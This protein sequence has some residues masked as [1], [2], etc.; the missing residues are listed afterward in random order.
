MRAAGELTL[1]KVLQ[2]VEQDIDVKDILPDMQ[3]MVLYAEH[4]EM[5]LGSG[6]GAID[7][8]YLLKKL[9]EKLALD[10]KAAVNK[11]KALSK[12]KVRT[13]MVQVR[14]L[15]RPFHATTFLTLQ[16]RFNEIFMPLP[17]T[18]CMTPACVECYSVPVQAAP[19]SPSLY[20]TGSASVV[21]CS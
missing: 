12:S 4:I 6:E 16:L 13:T 2:L 15:S 9:P 10:S 19:C 8:E 14:P 5:Q 20:V 1:D 21:A 18:V 7:T 17:I 3:R 11:A